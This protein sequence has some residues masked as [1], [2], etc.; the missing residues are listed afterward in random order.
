MS[1][2]RKSATEKITVEDLRLIT[3]IMKTLDTPKILLK[4]TVES[5]RPTFQIEKFIRHE[6][7]FKKVTVALNIAQTIKRL[8]LIPEEMPAEHLLLWYMAHPDDQPPQT[9]S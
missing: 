7:S 9:P 1:I 3:E 8:K 6:G 5:H 4:L 2:I